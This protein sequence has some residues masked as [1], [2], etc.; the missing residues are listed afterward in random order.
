MNSSSYQKECMGVK[1]CVQRSRLSSWIVM[2]KEGKE[3]NREGG[4]WVSSTVAAHPNWPHVLEQFSGGRARG[5]AIRHSL[6]A[7]RLLRKYTGVEIEM[8]HFFK[9]C[10]NTVVAVQ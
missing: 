7:Q 10:P 6:S 1:E 3:R 4:S 5:T 8:N 9:F 2:V